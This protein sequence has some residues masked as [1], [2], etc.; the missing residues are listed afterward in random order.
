MPTP[1]QPHAYPQQA[2]LPRHIGPF[3]LTEIL[4][5]AS[6]V[7][8][9]GIIGLTVFTLGPAVPAHA[10]LAS[11]CLFVPFAPHHSRLFGS[12]VC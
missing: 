2:R 12:Q 9:L 5:A 10:G 3:A 4:A 6:I 8:A 11:P 1:I 7:A